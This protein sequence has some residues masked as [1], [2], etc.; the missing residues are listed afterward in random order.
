MMRDMNM[1][2]LR[3]VI[4]ATL[5]VI[6][7][8]PLSAF[9][10]SPLEQEFAPTGSDSTKTYTIVN[11][12]AD[13]IAV[14]VTALTR[15]L[16]SNG[17]ETN[18]NASAYFSI[19]PSKVLLKPQS[20]QIVRVQYRGPRT[21][22]T[23]LAFR[24]KAEQIPYSKGRASEDTSMFNFLYVYTTSAY[25]APSRT[26]EKVEVVSV[27]PAKTVEGRQ[28]LSLEVE[29]TGAVHQILND[30]KIEVIENATRKSVI[31]QGNALGFANGL[32]LLADKKVRVNLAWPSTFEFPSSSAGASSLFTTKISYGDQ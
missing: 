20:S 3:F 2:K 31:Y 23:E 25:I 17:T 11:D 21:V 30:L 10:F 12:S 9:Q 4:I 14:E 32:N 24:I 6:F 8:A 29:N 28:V 19:V 1:N 13:T 5:L 27:T 15:D 22:P 16:S 18:A 26:I 7:L